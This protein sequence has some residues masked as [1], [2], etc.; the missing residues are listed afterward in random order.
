MHKQLGNRR[1]ALLLALVGVIGIGAATWATIAG[2]ASSG[3]R[4]LVST[5]RNATLGKTVLV[6]RK[7]LTL[8]SLSVERRGRFVCKDGACLSVWKP[9][10]VRKGAK[11]TGV[12]GLATVKR[13]D[14]RVQVTFRGRP[15]YTFY[16]DRR[17]GDVKGEGFKDVG[18][19]HAAATSASKSKPAPAPSGGGYG[20]YGGGY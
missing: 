17:R 2:G 16:L 18:T 9:L 1:G 13:P 14:G 4:P 12:R 20:G 15:L 19:W 7:G 3:P 11:P 8:Y 6:D 5:A 10:T